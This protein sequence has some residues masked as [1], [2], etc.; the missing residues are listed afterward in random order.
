MYKIVQCRFSDL[1]KI[2][3]RHR[4]DR[5]PGHA[6]QRA[7]WEALGRAEANEGYDCGRRH[8]QLLLRDERVADIALFPVA[9]ATPE[10]RHAVACAHFQGLRGTSLCATGSAH[11]AL[12]SGQNCSGLAMSG[13]RRFNQLLEILSLP[14][15]E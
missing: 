8:H 6:T 15:R 11:Q 2:A 9:C 14:V 4:V 12:M 1:V 5:V 13:G 10:S 3:H 7:T